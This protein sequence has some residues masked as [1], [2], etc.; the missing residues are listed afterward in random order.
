LDS[1]HSPTT[2]FRRF[3]VYAKVFTQILDSS[4]AEDYQTRHVFEDLLK[5]C[6][7]N[8]VVDMTPEAIARRTNVPLEIIK[9][10]IAD[11]EKP[12]PRSRNPEH[13]GRRIILLDEHRDW[14][15]MIC[16][17]DHYRSIASEEQR[18]EKTRLRVQRH[19]ERV[20][21]AKTNAS[22]THPNATNAMQKKRKVSLLAGDIEP[23]PSFPKS[24]EEAKAHAGFVGCPP[25]FA[26]TTYHL[27][28]S[29]GFTDAKGRTIHN[30]RSYLKIAH[31]YAKDRNAR[32]QNRSRNQGTISP[33]TD[34]AAAARA[35]GKIR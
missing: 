34:T 12:D 33:P 3:A 22:L 35:A 15:W 7:I 2:I 32:S 25:E 14:G 17:Y 28:C 5:L 27:A 30:F 19:A 21:K 11:L 24:E 4:L 31:S 10:G 29:R 16:N 18:R 13:D 26:V 1:N 23:P 20:K 6:D 9:R 8:G